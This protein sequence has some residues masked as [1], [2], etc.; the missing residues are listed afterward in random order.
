MLPI[1]HPFNDFAIDLTVSR[2]KG[3]VREMRNVVVAGGLTALLMSFSALAAEAADAIGSM[4]RPS[5]AQSVEAQPCS[6]GAHQ[7][8]D[9]LTQGSTHGEAPLDSVP[10]VDEAILMGPIVVEAETIPGLTAVDL[11]TAA[12]GAVACQEDVVLAQHALPYAKTGLAFRAGWA[13]KMRV[14]IDLPI[15]H[16]TYATAEGCDWSWKLRD[17]EFQK[18]KLIEAR[19]GEMIVMKVQCDVPGRNGW[20]LHVSDKDYGPAGNAYPVKDITGAAD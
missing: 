2:S 10:P 15:L 13:G 7:G 11:E 9:L 16:F 14:G 12:N 18:G 1:E 6:R 5:N 20:L 3:S 8:L 4:H 19:P 17:G